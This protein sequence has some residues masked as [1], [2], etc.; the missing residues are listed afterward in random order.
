MTAVDVLFRYG[1]PPME[2][3]MVAFGQLSDV[4]GIRRLRLQES[5]RTI[6][7][8]YDATRLTEAKVEGLL[9]AAGL[10]ITAK[11]ALV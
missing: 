9:R 10:D 7:V 4:Y 2:S 5:D 1:A 8:E 11:L 3:A 6:R